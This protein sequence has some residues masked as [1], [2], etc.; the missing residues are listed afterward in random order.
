MCGPSVLQATRLGSAT[1]Q[2]WVGLWRG[3]DASG[4]QGIV[5]LWRGGEWAHYVAPLSSSTPIQCVII[6]YPISFS[7]W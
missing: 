5:G 3:G 2:Q 4:Q 6:L 1:G 7:R